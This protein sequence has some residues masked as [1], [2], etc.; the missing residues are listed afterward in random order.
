[1]C[2][3]PKQ[4]WHWSRLLSPLHDFIIHGLILLGIPYFLVVGVKR[5]MYFVQNLSMSSIAKSSAILPSGLALCTHSLWVFSC[6]FPWNISN[7]IAS[8][9]KWTTVQLDA[10]SNASWHQRIP[11][12]TLFLAYA[13]QWLH[14]SRIP[15]SGYRKPPLRIAF[16]TLY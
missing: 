3:L 11:G 6:I 12:E 2:P 16:E 7:G 13:M 10:P 14:C 5:I 1:M 8:I 4:L 9:H 15:L